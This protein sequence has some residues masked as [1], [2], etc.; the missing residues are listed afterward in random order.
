MELIVMGHD[1]DFMVYLCVYIYIYYVY[2]NIM[3]QSFYRVFG[4][5]QLHLSYLWNTTTALFLFFK[6]R[7]T[8]SSAREPSL[9]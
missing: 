5:V 2:M 4:A 7:L 9:P 6:G 1:G 8:D 3:E